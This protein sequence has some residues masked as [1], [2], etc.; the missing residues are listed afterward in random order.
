MRLL[1]LFCGQG[2]AANLNWISA[3]HRTYLESEG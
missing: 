2:L 3:A 1:D